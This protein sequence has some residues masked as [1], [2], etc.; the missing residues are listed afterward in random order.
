MRVPLLG[1][2]K[3]RELSRVAKEEDRG[4]IE[5]PVPVPFVRSKLDSEA[6]GIAS[7]IRRAGLAANSGETNGSPNFLANLSEKRLRGDIAEVVS[8]LEIAMSTGSFGVDLL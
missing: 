5:D 4:I 1:V 3:V 2:N 7:T 8:N 6:T